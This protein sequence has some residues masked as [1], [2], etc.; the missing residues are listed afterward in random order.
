MPVTPPFNVDNVNVA[1]VIVDESIVLLNV[2]VMAVFTATLVAPLAGLVD[3]TVGA[4]DAEPVVKLHEYADAIAL[5]ALSFT[6]VESV[7]V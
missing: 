3:D 1:E 2:A 5:P 4:P 6:P 7:A